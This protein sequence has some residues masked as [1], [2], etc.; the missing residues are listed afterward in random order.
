M[1]FTHVP[2]QFLGE[3]VL[4][5]T[6][7]INRMPSRVLNFKTPS[8]VL[9]QAFPH[10]KLLSSLDPKV[11]GCSVFVHIHHRGKLDPT[12]L[13]CIFIGYSPH[14]KGYKCYSHVLKKVYTSMD[15]TFFEHQAYY[16]KSDL[17]GATMR[18]YH[19]WDI[20]SDHVIN[21]GDNQQSL[22]QSHLSPYT[23]TPT[24]IQSI[25][26]PPASVQSP[27]QIHPTPKQ[28][29]NHELLTYSRRK[30]LG[31]EIKHT[32]PLAHDQDS[33]PSPDSASIYSGMETSDCENTA[34][35]IDDLNIPITLRKGVGSC[36]SHPISKF[37]SYEGLSPTYH[38][39]VSTI[40]SV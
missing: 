8:Q 31:N 27:N 10:T 30:K 22:V 28:I 5:T 3:A 17:Q 6:Y 16:P 12:S 11:F 21:P 18:E 26:A 36:T 4:T 15:V 35:V 29:T 7:L 23:T 24:S 38:A 2:K 13:K 19:N 32:I 39:F 25:S 1:L 9:L 20:Q 14:Q 34:F 33:E 37:V 40:D